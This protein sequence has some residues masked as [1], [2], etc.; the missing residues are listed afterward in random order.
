M[1]ETTRAALTR[2]LESAH[3]DL[4]VLAEDVVFTTMATGDEH[5]GR[6]GV[7]AMLHHVYHVAFDAHAEARTLVCEHDHAVLEGLFVG[8]HIGEFAGVPATGKDVRVPLCVVYDLSEGKIRRGR[9]YLELP[10]LLRQL[11][12]RGSASASTARKRGSV[13]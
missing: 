11:G 5:H 4:S 9:V 1:S 2:Y 8:R 10:V 3:T 13:R 12:A 6:A 7:G